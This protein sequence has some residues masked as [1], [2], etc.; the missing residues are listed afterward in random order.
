[1]ARLAAARPG[2]PR[3]AEHVLTPLLECDDAETRKL[4]A[5]ALAHLK[6]A[7]CGD[8]ALQKKTHRLD[9][10]LKGSLLKQKDA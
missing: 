6:A 7:A 3:D 8:T 5:E 4:A 9:T 10:N 2:L 1:V